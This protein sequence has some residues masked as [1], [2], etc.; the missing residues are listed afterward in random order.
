[1]VGRP[2]EVLDTYNIWS[3]ARVVCVLAPHRLCVQF[4]GWQDAWCLWLD[5]RLDLP[6]IRALTSACQGL[7]ELGGMTIERMRQVQDGCF[8]HILK[9]AGT[10]ESASK[11]EKCYEDPYSLTWPWALQCATEAV[12]PCLY[13]RTLQLVLDDVT[14]HDPW[15]DRGGGFTAAKFDTDNQHVAACNARLED[16]ATS[17]RFV[18]MEEPGRVGKQLQITWCQQPSPTLP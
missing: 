15:G 11:F 6:R 17:S 1:M 13:V 10:I 14:V 16:M 18:D 12:V 8:V 4:D 9:Q 7:G 2:V 3:V 5:R